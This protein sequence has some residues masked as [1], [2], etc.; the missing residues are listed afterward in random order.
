MAES[1]IIISGSQEELKEKTKEL[2][3][4]QQEI[5]EKEL[6]LSTF[7]RDLHLFEKHYHQE[8]GP[9]YAKLDNVRA[10]VLEL[11]ARLEPQKEQ[12]RIDADA[13]REEADQA[14]R[15]AHPIQNYTPIEKKSPPTEELKRFF[16]EAAKKFHPDL[17]TDEK[18]RER[19]HK[20][21]TRLNQAY[22]ELDSTKIKALL[23]EWEDE[24]ISETTMSFSERLVKTIRQ[25][26]Q[27]KARLQMIHHELTQ[28][29]NSE[30][31][32]LKARVD[33]VKRNGRDIIQE[34]IAYLETKISNAKSQV[35]KLSNDLTYL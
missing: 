1:T 17:T 21:M 19:R 32:K 16:R 3:S 24:E 7:K 11:A 34:M 23:N 13:A 9:K 18:E 12:L 31:F 26:S 35:R 4:L 14:I 30:M 27:I 20:L 8:V 10:L 2:A 33:S 28:L 5:A 22:N 6:L 15:N 25:I 29:Q